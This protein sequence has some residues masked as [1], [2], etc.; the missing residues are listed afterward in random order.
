MTV[1]VDNMRA[2]FGRMVMCHMI[3]TTKAELLAMATAIGVQHKWIQH[4]GSAK[5]HFDIALTKRARAVRAGAVEITRRQ[6]SCMC[7]RRRITGELG[8]P[9]DAERWAQEY[10]AQR[11]AQ[12]Q[13]PA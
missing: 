4:P 5:E 13:A 2:D 10:A 8:T 6:C 9:E 1:Y 7:M 11:S 3:A 12:A